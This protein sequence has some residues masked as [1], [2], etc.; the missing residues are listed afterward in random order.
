MSAR[1]PFYCAA[2]QA[3]V[4][5]FRPGPAGRPAAKCPHC[6]SLE[7]HR[8]LSLLLGVMAPQLDDVDTMVE[9]AP[10]PQSTA[11][12]DRVP[13]RR[14]IRFDIGYDNRAVHALASITD[15]PLPDASVDLLVC[16]HVLEHVPDDG[17]AMREIAR[18]LSPRGVALLQVPIRV[19]VPTD[20]DPSADRDERIRRFGQHDHVR[21][22]GDDF[23]SRLADAGLSTE[24]VTPVELLGQRAVVRFGLI[25]HEFVWI[26]R[27]GHRVVRPLAYET[28]ATGLTM[29]LDALVD[30]SEELRRTLRRARRR[31][32]RLDS[33]LKTLAPPSPP[34]VA[35][36]AVSTVRRLIAR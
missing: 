27:R 8:F 32:E 15:L 34:D 4:R 11:Q 20:E 7:R 26:A 17:A 10:A 24:R 25:S 5:R 14:R 31:A 33:R 6:K 9:I 29:A 3:S 16:Y 35:T 30:E 21:Y 22:Y 23:E 1:G 36:R 2:C 19:G 18:V 28:R 12:L 13:A